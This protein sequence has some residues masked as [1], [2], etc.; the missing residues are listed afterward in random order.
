MKKEPNMSYNKTVEELKETF[1]Q[2]IMEDIG[3]HYK[4]SDSLFDIL[5]DSIPI[6]LTTFAEK[7]REGIVEEVLSIAEEYKIPK[8]AII[9]NKTGADYIFIYDL[10]NKLNEAALT[11]IATELI[12]EA[13]KSK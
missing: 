8:E 7:I 4:V 5:A 9:I 2:T 1:F 12:A 3:K 6:A 11:E 10:K 13:E